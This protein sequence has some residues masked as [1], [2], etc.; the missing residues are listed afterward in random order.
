MGKT[1]KD[2][3]NGKG[4]TKNSSAPR[5]KRAK[6]AEEQATAQRNADNARWKMERRREEQQADQRK[7]KALTGALLHSRKQATQIIERH[8]Q[9]AGVDVGHVLYEYRT[10][11]EREVW[12]WILGNRIDEQAETDRKHQAYFEKK[13]AEERQLRKAA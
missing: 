5:A 6:S 13:Q 7:A 4:K 9:F 1:G 8:P 12:V 3:G 10:L 2:S 11:V